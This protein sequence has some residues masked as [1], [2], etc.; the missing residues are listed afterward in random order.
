[1]SMEMETVEVNDADVLQLIERNTPVEKLC[2]GFRFSEG[3]IWNPRE[4]C[5][6]FSDM[7]SDIRRRWSAKDGVV[8]VRNPSNKCN[9]MTY[10]EVGNLYVCEHVT[11]SLVMETTSGQ[12]RVLASHW[13]GK[14]LNSPNDVVLRSDGTVYFTD[15]TYGRMPVFGLERAQELA[16]QGV[17]RVA[18]DGTLHCEADDF[19]QPNG[20]CLAPDETILYVN[21]TTRAHIRA[22]DVSPDGALSNGRVFADQIGKGDYDEGVVDGMKCDERGNIYVSGPRGIWVISAQGKHLGVIRMPEIVGNLNWGGPD[23]NELYCAC[24]TSIYRVRT[25]VRSNPVAYMDM[26]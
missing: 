18:V 14:E 25:T 13:Q 17:Y 8:E 26:K 16:F 4:G 11:S 6:Y 22:F 12:R 3:P 9:G 1:M 21:D 24:S 5:L 15:P 20:L 7:P 23:W 19:S 10:D 2:T